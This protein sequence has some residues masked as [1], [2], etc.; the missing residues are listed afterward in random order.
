M[1][2]RGRC[3]SIEQAALSGPGAVVEEGLEAATSS[4]VMKKGEQK[5]E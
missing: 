2:Q 3:F 1:P 5:D 4:L